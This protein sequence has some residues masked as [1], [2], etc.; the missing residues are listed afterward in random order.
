MDRDG[1]VRL[2]LVLL[3][4][5]S[6]GACSSSS[7]GPEGP[8]PSG[9]ASCDT[10]APLTV[11]PVPLGAIHEIAP[12]GSLF[13][14][15]HTTPTGHIYFYFAPSGQ[16]NMTPV[17][18]VAPGDIV[19]TEVLQQTRSG[20][21]L[22]AFVDYALTFFPCADLRLFLA[23]LTSLDAV[24]TARISSLEANCRPSYSTGGFS[25]QQCVTSTTVA[26]GSGESLGTVSG[27]GQ[28][29]LDFGGAD[30]RVTP[31][32]FVNPSRSP[33]ANEP[34]G[35][36]RTICPVDYFTPPV[37]DALRTLFGRGGERRNAPPV[38]GEV[39]QDVAG[40][41]QG[42]WFRGSPAQDD[43]NLALVHDNVNPAIAAISVGTAV[44]SLPSRVYRFVPA[45]SGRL[46]S[47]FP[48]VT[49]GS[50]IHCYDATDVPDALVFLQ[51]V[52]ATR[53]QIEGRPGASCGDPSTWAFTSAATEFE[54]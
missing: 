8:A 49:V 43:L 22:P 45:S 36:N 3:V 7:I 19:V 47:D 24:L 50:G 9:L 32:A 27:P 16:A 40:T 30:R 11:S 20:G 28:G 6:V 39:M 34:F 44:P 2:F 38:C 10:G 42:R 14:P 12:L 25:Y 13:P 52:S 48:L 46:N 53:L 26:V 23:H 29:A 33:G 18:L 51:L 4:A 17:P 31:L 21:G 15:G 35:A 5:T 54:R 1:L 41:A 37:R